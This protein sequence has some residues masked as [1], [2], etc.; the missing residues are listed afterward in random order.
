MN[1]ETRGESRSRRDSNPRN[2]VNHLPDPKSGAI[3][4]YATAPDSRHC[5]SWRWPGQCTGP[6]KAVRTPASV[7]GAPLARDSC[8]WS[9]RVVSA[10]MATTFQSGR[11]AGY[12]PATRRL[13][14]CC[15]ALSYARHVL[16]SGRDGS[17][18]SC[19]FSF[20][21]RQ[22]SLYPQDASSRLNFPVDR[23]TQ[24]RPAQS[25]EKIVPL[26]ALTPQNR[27]AT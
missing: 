14:I 12:D 25:S 26:M 27:Q 13:Q 9:S 23:S 7:H 19:R 18:P 15:S 20:S 4:R 6:R 8:C 11:A 3:G 22:R 17:R 24:I 1:T 2:G 21:T 16:R 10:T 5:S